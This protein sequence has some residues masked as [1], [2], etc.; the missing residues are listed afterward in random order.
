MIVPPWVERDDKF[1]TATLL[2]ILCLVLVIML[3]HALL[4]YRFL[5]SSAGGIRAK[6][7]DQEDRMGSRYVI[8]QDFLL[9]SSHCF[10][11]VC[12]RSLSWW[13]GVEAIK[14]F[15]RKD[16]ICFFVY[17]KFRIANEY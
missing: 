5:W 2:S 14:K 8:V 1:S 15:P 16:T 12:L 17:C 11:V 6:S 7:L 3:L 13:R 10:V 4:P 9:F